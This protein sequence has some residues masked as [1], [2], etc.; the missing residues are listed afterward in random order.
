[1]CQGTGTV[2]HLAVVRN[3]GAG[4]PRSAPDET[5]PIPLRAA[6]P[7]AADALALAR[8]QRETEMELLI[9]RPDGTGS[10]LDHQ[11]LPELYVERP[12]A[13]RAWRR[14]LD[15]DATV[16]AAVGEAGRGK[17]SLMCT[18]A[19]ELGEIAPVFFYNGSQLNGRLADALAEG[20]GLRR[21]GAD[22]LA[23]AAALARQ[24][25]HRLY[26][27]ID[28]LNERAVGRD[29]LRTEL[30]ELARAIRRH[31]WPIRLVVSCRSADW[32]F[33]VRNA[34]NMLSHFGR[35]VHRDEESTDGSVPGTPV[36]AFDTAETEGG[37][38]PSFKVPSLL[39]LKALCKVVVVLSPPSAHIILRVQVALCVEADLNTF[40]K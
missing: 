29:D 32:P 26:V 35:A 36:A 15:S 33:W 14:F 20:L 30:N 37:C 24:Q 5:R 17:T 25:G 1:M 19:A 40:D 10:I 3:P 21:T 7:P 38:A 11:H 18:L 8:R 13:R 2:E 22:A 34:R 12:A 28:A 31:R 6:G 39:V 9:G 27:F 4:Q 23:A 16:F